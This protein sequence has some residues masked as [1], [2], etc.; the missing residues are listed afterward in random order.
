MQSSTAIPFVRYQVIP[1]GASTCNS[2]WWNGAWS[3]ACPW[4]YSTAQWARLEPATSRSRVRRSNRW[5]PEPRTAQHTLRRSAKKLNIKKRNPS[6][7]QSIEN[8]RNERS[9]RLPP[10]TGAEIRIPS[11]R[12]RHVYHCRITFGLI[13]VDCTHFF[14][15]RTESVTRGGDLHKIV[16]FHAQKGLQSVCHLCVEWFV[17]WQCR[18][19]IFI[20]TFKLSINSLSFSEYLEFK[21]VVFFYGSY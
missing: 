17:L 21:R 14:E 7:A 12:R 5:L 11:A 4:P 6:P 10:K 3:S 1:L 19:F 9:W 16:Q 2:W 13:D 8:N 18:L 20:V 15:I